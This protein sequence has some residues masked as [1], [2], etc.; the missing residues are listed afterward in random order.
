MALILS[1]RSTPARMPFIWSTQRSRLQAYSLNAEATVPENART[2]SHTASLA[3]SNCPLFK[4]LPGEI[5]NTIYAH[6]LGQGDNIHVTKQA[7][8]PEPALLSTCKA[9]RKEAIGM[10]Y[11]QNK[12]YVKIQPFEV[13]A[14][15]LWQTKRKLLFQ[16]YGLEVAPPTYER[17]G[18]RE[19]ANL[20]TWMRLH[21][22]DRMAAP[23]ARSAQQKHEDHTIKCMFDFAARMAKDGHPWA[24]V[25]EGGLR[26]FR[27]ELIKSHKDWKD[28]RL[29]P[30]LQSTS[31]LWVWF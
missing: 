18:R 11:C 16:I 3:I 10:F 15:M 24:N 25:V 20:M 30:S 26:G 14:F 22:A 4:Q 19:W 13:T 28:E 6:A 2:N 8:I 29:D 21:H 17:T 23:S 31:A 7:G 27:R 5:R 1:A 9:I 12:I